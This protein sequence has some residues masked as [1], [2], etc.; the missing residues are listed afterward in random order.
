MPS[1]S[2][3]GI[4]G[5]C[6]YICVIIIVSSIERRCSDPMAGGTSM[7]PTR[8]LLMCEEGLPVSRLLFVGRR[9]FTHRCG[10]LQCLLRDV[11]FGALLG[12]DRLLSK[13]EGDGRCFLLCEILRSKAAC[14]ASPRAAA[15]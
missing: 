4:F 5:D 10:T 7:R 6:S 15:A 13:P 14:A 9:T 8:S 11:M 12:V 3:S 2:S 1:F